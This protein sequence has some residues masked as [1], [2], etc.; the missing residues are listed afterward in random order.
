MEEMQTVVV[1]TEFEYKRTQQ[2]R[3]FWQHRPIN[4][5]FQG[6]KRKILQSFNNRKK[7]K[8]ILNEEL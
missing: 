3:N 6:T 4:F 8:Y 7:L 1:E 2:I 5:M